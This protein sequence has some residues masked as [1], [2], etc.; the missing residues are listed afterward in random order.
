MAECLVKLDKQMDALL[1]F[2]ES[3]ELISKIMG[4]GHPIRGRCNSFYVMFVFLLT[5]W[6]V[7]LY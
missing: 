4:D 6:N 2:H 7:Y 5:V 3:S 1:L